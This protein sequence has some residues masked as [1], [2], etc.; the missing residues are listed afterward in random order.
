MIVIEI[1]MILFFSL[2]TTSCTEQVR[3]N[4][5]RCVILDLDAKVEF[6]EKSEG[7]YTLPEEVPHKPKEP[8]ETEPTSPPPN[9]KEIITPSKKE[10]V[11]MMTISEIKE[12][13]KR[14][15]Q[16][17]TTL[18]DIAKIN[19][20]SK[21]DIK[22]YVECYSM[23]KMPKYDGDEEVTEEQ[24]QS[25]FKNRN[26]VEIEEMN[27]PRRGIVVS[28][29]NMKSFPTDIKFFKTKGATNFD[30]IQETE[31]TMNTPALILHESKDELWYFIKTQIYS[32]WVKKTDVAIASLSDWDY[33]DESSSFV[34]VTSH[35]ILI[36]GK[37]IDMGV[38]L[39]VKR[40]LS[41]E[42]EVDIPIKTTSGLVS[43][44]AILLDKSSISLGY[45]PYTK[46]NILAQAQ[47]YMGMP[48]SWGGM[49]KGVDCSSFIM[50]IY[51]T[52]GFV[53]PRNTSNQNSSVGEV[54]SLSGKI[55]SQKLEILSK[56]SDPVIL[57]QPGHTMLYIGMEN[58]KHYIVHASGSEMKVI[59]TQLENST[60]LKNIDRI[61][62]IAT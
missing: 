51:K 23:P 58:G 28:R 52:F 36:D 6:E 11:V 38:R 3:V 8:T 32:G 42:V 24:I 39:P 20:L 53:F 46:E 60:Y 35:S 61:V 49:D 41:S 18:S 55:S 27:S 43:K 22:K 15:A 62:K 7:V 9:E 16:K 17:T 44:K 48:Y 34:V 21:E 54:I 19:Y 13:N 56:Q 45:L 47:K 57:Y 2:F 5:P 31:I 12:H 26:I 30:Q 29:T 14:I 33:F 1:V 40:G 59:K 25:I 50:N 37:I 4:Y 10:D